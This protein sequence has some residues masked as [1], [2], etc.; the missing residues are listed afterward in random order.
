MQDALRAP[1]ADDDGEANDVEDRW[2]A[3]GQATLSSVVALAMEACQRL[4]P[5]HGALPDV[6]HSKF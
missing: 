1:P 3:E 5:V 6:I 4:K 2:R